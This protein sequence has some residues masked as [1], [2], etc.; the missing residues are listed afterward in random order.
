M[1]LQAYPYGSEQLNK[2]K[3]DGEEHLY[4]NYIGTGR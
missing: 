1:Q 4:F 3:S 2:S